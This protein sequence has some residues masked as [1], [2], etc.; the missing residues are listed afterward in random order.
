MLSLPAVSG[1][2]REMS[3]PEDEHSIGLLRWFGGKEY[4]CDARDTR[5]VGS[6]PKLE[7]TPGVGKLLKYSCIKFHGQRNLVGCSLWAT[8]SWTKL[9][10]IM[11]IL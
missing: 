3:L 8:K 2:R 11:N 1:R 7:K 4:T 5:D 6:I 10:A 9:N